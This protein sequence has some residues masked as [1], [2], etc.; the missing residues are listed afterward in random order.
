MRH[1]RSQDF[2]CGCLYFSHRPQYTAPP[3]RS[4]KLAIYKD[5]RYLVH[6]STLEIYDLCTKY[7][8]LLLQEHWLSP[9]ELDYLNNIHPDFLACGQSAMDIS[10]GI[11][12]GRP[13]GGTAIL[14]RKS[15]SQCITRVPTN[16][17]RI[18]AV[19]LHSL[20]GPVLIV[21]VYMPTDYGDSESKENYIATCAYISALYQE[22]NAILM[23]TAGDFNCQRGSRFY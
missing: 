12:I 13:Y 17:H 14:Y 21:S 23:I 9:N 15:L 19:M 18:T 20:I 5:R 7:D 6:S 11:I 10:Q 2:R 8:V 16:N 22:S 4:S 1:R 3:S